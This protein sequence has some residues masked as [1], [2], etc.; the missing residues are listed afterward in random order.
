MARWIRRICRFATAVMFVGVGLS[1]TTPA[2]AQADNPVDPSNQPRSAQTID[3][4]GLPVLLRAEEVT[5]DQELG[6]IVARGSVEIARGEN[7]ILADTLSYNR[8]AKTITASG[9]VQIL[10]P[11]G[12]VI[13]AEYVELSE[14]MMEG[15]VENLR[16]LLSDNARI[17]AAGGRRTRGNTIDMARAVYSPCEVCQEDPDSPPLWQVKADRVVHDREARQVDYY[18][19]TV[20]VYGMP[21]AY[22]PYFTHPDPSVDRQSGVLLPTYGI[23]E[24]T[25]TFVRVPYFWAIDDSQDITFDPIYTDIQGGIFSGEYRKHFDTGYVETSGSFTYADRE[26]SDATGTV[27]KRDEF[28]G[29]IFSRGTFHLDETWRTGWNINRSTDKTYLRKFNFWT[30]PGGFMTSDVYTEG[31]RGRNYAS[32]RAYS[33]QD[34]RL[35]DQSKTPLILPLLDYDGIGEADSYGGRWSLDANIRSLTDEDDAD[36]QRVSV[37]AGYTKDFFTPWGLVTSLTGSLRGDVYYTDHRDQVNDIGDKVEDGFAGRIIPRVSAEMRYPLAHYSVGG[38]Q[39]IEPIVALHAAPNGGNPTDIRND[40][41]S[42]FETDDGNVLSANRLAGLDRVETGQKAVGGI[43]LGDYSDDGSKIT[44]FLGHSYRFSQD[45]QLRREVQ[46]ENQ[47]SDW[48]GRLE[49]APSEF[50]NAYYQFNIKRDELESNRN[51]VNV[52]AGGDGLRV[53]TQYD[54]V[55]SNFDPNTA[56]FEQLNLTISSKIAEYWTVSGSTLQD[57]RDDSDPLNYGLFVTYEDECFIFNGTFQRLF[58]RSAD[59]KQEDILLF[60]VN[61]KTLGEVE[62]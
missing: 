62:F 49:V 15:T 14:D 23:T 59:V 30:D 26:E 25:G 13:F 18:D 58:T 45:K 34:L 42:L 33:F 27:L 54:F 2:A 28:R 10:E 19:A 29:H 9:N 24:N 61:F 40:D 37:K 32:A 22:F 31:F 52:T 51:S 8:N 35:G 1:A 55:R 5:Q 20:E 36:S 53:S 56:Q 4:E 17:A 21:V 16:V 48:V 60:R 50:F 39:V 6:V 38:R 7:I 47:R 57:L 12:E 11:S 43:K 3:G 41:S 44:L 46:M